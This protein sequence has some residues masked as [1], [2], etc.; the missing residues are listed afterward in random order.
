MHRN[1]VTTISGAD[2][3]SIAAQQDGYIW[4]KQVNVIF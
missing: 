3:Y 4:S 2:K 1:L